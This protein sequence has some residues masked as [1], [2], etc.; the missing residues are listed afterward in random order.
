MRSASTASETLII[1][2][3]LSLVLVLP[4]VATA[5]QF[6]VSGFYRQTVGVDLLFWPGARWS[7]AI[8]MNVT[9]IMGLMGLLYLVGIGFLIKQRTLG[10]VIFVGIGAAV[11]ATLLAEVVNGFT[12][13][14]ELQ[15]VHSMDLAGKAN[16]AILSLWHNPIWEELV[17]RGFPLVCCLAVAKR[18]PFLGRTAKGCYFLVPS[19]VFAAYHVPGHG[20]SR[21]VDT[22]ILSLAF[23]WLALRYR[24]HAVIVLHC[25]FDAMMVPGLGKMNNIPQDEVQWLADRAGLFNTVQSVAVLS[26]VALMLAHIA[27]HAWKSRRGIVEITSGIGA[28]GRSDSNRR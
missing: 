27:R 14:R 1:Q 6:W 16:K 20:Y 12:G 19:I 13:W 7:W 26:V 15:H 24:F 25:I 3:L 23:A 5:G 2:V 22:F 4:L 17:F 28:S 18:W 11:A 21:I 10:K 9:L 8:R